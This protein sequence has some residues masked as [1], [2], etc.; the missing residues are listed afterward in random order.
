MQP[1]YVSVY[2]SAVLRTA[3]DN[4]NIQYNETTHTHLNVKQKL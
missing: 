3:V 2:F 4:L 1:A